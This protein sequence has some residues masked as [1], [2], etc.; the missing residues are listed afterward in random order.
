MQ[1]RGVAMTKLHLIGGLFLI[2]VLTGA[3]G[4]SHYLDDD[5]LAN[6]TNEIKNL[7]STLNSTQQ[8]L[9]STKLALQQL[10][11]TPVVSQ[12]QGTVAPTVVPTV[13]VTT[14]SVPIITRF[15]AMP[16]IIT[17]GQSSTLQWNISGANSVY[18]NH[19]IGA[20]SYVGARAVYP[21]STTIYTITAA[22][23]Y[24]SITESVTIFV[25]GY[26]PAY[27]P[28]YF[29]PSPPPIIPCPPPMPPAPHPWPPA[30]HPWP[31][32]PHPCPPAPPSM[33]LVI[34]DS[35]PHYDN[36]LA[37]YTQPG[38]IRYYRSD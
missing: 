30:P 22:N 19:G 38:H 24:E 31:P 8:E 17:A 3:T 27:Y 13:Q 28:L 25:E 7:K 15:T 37:D 1:N 16:G 18:I 32:T 20:V 21:T 33:P 9:A 34:D 5:Q 6:L 35:L 26:S 23:G 14:A 4:C 2:L 10:Q 11:N 29:H 12:S 36:L